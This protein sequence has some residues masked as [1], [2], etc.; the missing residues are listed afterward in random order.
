MRIAVNGRFSHRKTG[1]G[2]VIEN[3][4]LHLEQ[5]DTENE[6]FIYVN[7]EFADFIHFKNPKF[8]LLSNGI[9]AG[10]SL[11]NHI[12]TQTGFLKEIRRRRAD[13]V[14]LPQINLFIFKMAPTILFQHDL[15]EYYMPNQ[16]WYKL[17][18]RK[19]T[20][21]VALRLSDRIVCV[22]E[23]TRDDVKKIFKV[24]DEKLEVIPNGVDMSLF[25]KLNAAEAKDIV[26]RKYNVKGDFI[27]YTGTLT[28]PQKNLVRLVEAY[29][30]MV[31]KGA[32]YKLVLVGSNGKDAHLISR[33]VKELGLAERVIFAGYV[34][35]EDLPYFY[36]AATVFCFPSLYEGFGLPVL[37]AMACGCPVV[38][39][40]TSSMP[41]VAGD[42]ALIVDPLKPEEIGAALL[43]LIQSEELRSTCITKGLR[44][45]GKYSWET[46]AGNL[47]RLISSLAQV[48]M[49]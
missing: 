1:V 42:A 41:G 5:V 6:Y 16:K 20:Y 7:R 13:V 38:T 28:L 11:L 43:R 31:R 3:V 23:N 15:I 30:M 24:A 10:N 33:K 19:M 49:R 26:E 40:N 36:N 2:R 39:S 21:P 37:E 27:L 8:H 9:P 29:E 25:R 32:K 22:S 18:F 48:H 14:I 45:A 44:Q 35:D 4:F 34:P 12:W 47:L 46:S 17:L